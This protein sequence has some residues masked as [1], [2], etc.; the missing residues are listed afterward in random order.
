[1]LNICD[2]GDVHLRHWNNHA[3][4]GIKMVHKSIASVLV[5]L[6]LASVIQAQTT[7]AINKL[8][9]VTIRIA[10]SFAHPSNTNHKVLL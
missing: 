5:I 9:P 10:V 8:V 3:A 7:Q 1:M 2:S 6:A 4:V